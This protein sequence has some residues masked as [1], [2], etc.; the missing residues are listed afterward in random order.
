[1]KWRED[2]SPWL[3]KCTGEGMQLAV[4]FE[5]KDYVKRMGGR[6]KPDPTGK[7]GRWWIPADKVENVCPYD[8]IGM[9]MH[10]AVGETVRDFL[11]KYKMVFSPYGEQNG[12]LC[13]EVVT[14]Y[15]SQPSF[16]S[17]KQFRLSSPNSELDVIWYAELGLCAF[18]SSRDDDEITSDWY[19]A[20]NGRSCWDQCVAEGFYRTA[21]AANNS[22]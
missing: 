22:A 10:V 14:D 8:D 16:L 18:R 12:D 9:E 21:A 7:G 6:W 5:E 19:T 2:Y 13:L 17:P 20:E 15:I 3:A 1:M 11:N 4:H